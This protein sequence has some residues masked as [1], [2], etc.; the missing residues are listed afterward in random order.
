MLSLDD[1]LTVGVNDKPA[2]LGGPQTDG[3]EDH[4]RRAEPWFQHKRLGVVPLRL[5]Q[6]ALEMLPPV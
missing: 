4:S 5:Y 3:N 2:F 6:C 1:H